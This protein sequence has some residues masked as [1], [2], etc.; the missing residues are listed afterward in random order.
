MIFQSMEDE[1]VKS[2]HL[3]LALEPLGERNGAA[4]TPASFESDGKTHLTPTPKAFAS[5]AL[6]GKSKRTAEF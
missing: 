1:W 3:T 4:F 6:R 5:P 2:K